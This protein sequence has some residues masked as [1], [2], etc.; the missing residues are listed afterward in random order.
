MKTLHSIINGH[1]QDEYFLAWIE[2]QATAL[3]L[4]GWARHLSDSEVEII[5]QG[6]E[7]ASKELLSKVMSGSVMT[8]ANSVKEE[9]LED[10]KTHSIFEIR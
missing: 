7:D 8:G 5:A 6:D 1:A 3:N 2:E 10:Y 9:W 4:T